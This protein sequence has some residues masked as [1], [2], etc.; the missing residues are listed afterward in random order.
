MESN[1]S[2]GM[3][4]ISLQAFERPSIAKEFFLKIIADQNP[5]AA[6]ER[7]VNATPPVFETEWLDFKGAAQITDN[8][9]K[10]TWSE[11]LAGFA[12]TQGGILI[13]GVD[14]RKSRATGIDTACGSSFVKNP[15]AF[16]SR[17]IEL[18]RQATEPPVL[19]VEIVAY[20]TV[21]S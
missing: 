8:D 7:L 15:S 21:A 13:W 4:D 3:S 2:R 5:V 11:A 12:N 14:A 16:K 19:G 10:K 6:I 17:L 1:Y 9:T 18:H 20:S